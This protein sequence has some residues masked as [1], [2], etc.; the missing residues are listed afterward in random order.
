[1][2]K[3]ERGL[4]GFQAMPLF[5]A[6]PSVVHFLWSLRLHV[7][8]QEA[9]IHRQTL[10]QLCHLPVTVLGTCLGCAAHL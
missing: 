2:G 6:L 5:L 1:M 10:F 9:L 3:P 8:V 7:D 4:S